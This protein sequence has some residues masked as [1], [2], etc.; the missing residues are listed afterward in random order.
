MQSER[1]ESVPEA[2]AADDLRA[3]RAQDAVLS[4]PL[5]EAGVSFCASVASQN[6]CK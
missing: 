5:T 1:L 2:L 3:R 4:L 6:C